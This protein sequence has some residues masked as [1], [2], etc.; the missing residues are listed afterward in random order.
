MARDAAAARPAAP[1]P[2]YV[3]VRRVDRPYVGLEPVDAWRQG[4]IGEAD[5]RRVLA[6]SAGPAIGADPGVTG[7]KR[8]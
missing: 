2:G 5:R 4:R 6:A 8:E 1:D 7:E 3:T